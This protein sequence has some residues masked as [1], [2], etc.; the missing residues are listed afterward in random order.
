MTITA[1]PR[2]TTLLLLTCCACQTVAT[3]PEGNPTT[4]T[5]GGDV[6][7]A[8]G[9]ANAFALDLYARI[10]GGESG[11]AFFSPTSITT[12][13]ALAYAGARG[14]TAEQMAKTLHFSLEGQALHRA[15]G[16]LARTIAGERPGLKITIANAIWGQQGYPFEQ[17]Y[18]QLGRD[19]Y[20]APLK[21]VDFRQAAEQARATINDW[22]EKETQGKI[23]ELIQPGSLDAMTRLV[24][25]NAIYFK[26]VWSHEFDPENTEQAPF[27]LAGGGSV[28]VEMMQA[29][30]GS[31]RYYETDGLQLL[32]LPYGEGQAS[33]VVLLPAEGR[34][35]AWLESELSLERL[36]GWLEDMRTADIDLLALPR[37]KLTCR[38][39][40]SQA[41]SAMGMRSAFAPGADFSGIAEVEQLYI[42]DVVHEATVEVNEEGTEAAAATGTMIRTT[43]MRPSYTFRADRPFLFLIRD[44]DSGAILFLGRVADPTAG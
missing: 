10:A 36:E 7:A 9:D 44:E 32:E 26:G 37:F 5:S 19:Y 8:A 42:S 12:A 16:D 24:L 21:P 27:H 29:R 11:N 34:S 1:G 2:L 23:D 22:V 43:A 38:Y 3:E 18:L 17:A 31:F 15:Q 41:L 4:K 14:S 30:D 39:G 28:P 13:L 20:G 33:M 25:T 6:R 35:L 40:L